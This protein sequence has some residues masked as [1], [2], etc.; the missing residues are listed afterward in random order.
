MTARPDPDMMTP[1]PLRARL[2]S[3]IWLLVRPWRWQLVLVALCILASAVLEL[4]PPF[5]V[6]YVVNHDLTLHQTSNL[7]TAGLVYLGAVVANAGFGYGYAILAARVSQWAIAVLRAQLFA[8]V[9]TLPTIYFDHTPIGDMISRLTSDVETVDELFTEGAITLI[10]QLVPLVAVAIAMIVLSPLLSLVSTVVLPPLLIVVRFLQVRVRNAERATRVEV[11][12]LNTQ[13]A[14]V[15]GGAETLHMFGREDVFVHRFRSALRRTLMAQRTSVKYGAF[16][17]PISGLLSAL[18]IAALLWVGAGHTL[19]TAGVDIGT[20]MAFVLLFQQFFA[21]IVSLGD[22]WQ[23]VQAAVAGSERVFE[24]LDIEGEKVPT[25]LRPSRSLSKGVVVSHVR[26]G[27]HELH[28][29]L[30]DV[31]IEVRPG[32]HVAVV[33]RSGAGKSTLLSL[34]GGLYAPWA[35]SVTINGVDPRS[36]SESERR[37]QLGVVPQTLDLFSGTLRDNLTLFDPTVDDDAIQRAIEVAGLGAVVEGMPEGLATLLSGEGRGIGAVLSAGERQLVALARSLVTK[38]AIVL[39]DEA[40]AAIDAASDVA[41]RLA[42]RDFS[43]QS[44]SAVLT[45]AHRVSTARD[46]DRVVVIEQGRVV[47]VGRPADLISAGGRFAALVELDTAG[48][49]WKDV[50][51]ESDDA[52]VTRGGTNPPS[53]ERDH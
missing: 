20:L 19:T 22:E 17:T 10:G 29:V 53:N 3:R 15:V 41:F 21:P 8:H 27:Y 30:N 40:T 25:R 48:W 12:R 50:S 11:G 16:F 2:S 39:L 4:I 42:L 45:V 7:V 6:R 24:I 44:G 32:E 31:S 13:L 9:M 5:V 46:A 52:P 36:L 38:P 23:L 49:E 18:A 34:I 33:G 26:F 14:E 28:P 47:E 37:L 35:G 51:V 43:S 1:A